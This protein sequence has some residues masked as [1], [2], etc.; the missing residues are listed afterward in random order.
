MSV[1][2]RKNIKIKPSPGKNMGIERKMARGGFGGG[3]DLR[4]CVKD[5]K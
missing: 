3:I 4:F 2:R 1:P 5:L